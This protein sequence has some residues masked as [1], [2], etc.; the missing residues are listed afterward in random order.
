MGILNVTPDSLRPGAETVPEGEEMAR[1]IPV[2]KG[3]ERAVKIP[4]SVDTTKAV[5][6]RAAIDSGAEIVNDISAMTFDGLMPAAIAETGAA[7]ILMH[8]R[9]TPKDMQKGDL[10][11]K[12][13]MGEIIEFLE[14]RLDKA[15][16]AGY[17]T[18][19]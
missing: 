16:T 8:M 14:D 9:G 12:S 7:V 1:V 18:R 10:T 17:R 6:A 19:L 13:L 4:I 11:C 2:I 3:L 5:V 15:G